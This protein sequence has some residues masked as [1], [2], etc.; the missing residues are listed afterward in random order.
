MKNKKQ[1][2]KIRIYGDK[3]LKKVADSVEEITPDLKKFI[4]N[5]TYTMYLTDGIGL[6]APQVGI[7]LRIFVVDPYWYKEEKKKNPRIFI[8]PEFIEFEGESTAEEGCLS[9][10]N[11]YEKVNRAQKVVISALDEYGKRFTLEAEDMFARVLQ[12]EFDHLEGVLFVE[13]IPKL[14]QVFIKKKLKELERSTDEN[15][16]NILKNED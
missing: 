10:P 4:E 15:G 5:L 3:T 13:K 12:H 7:S 16:V 9:L 1:L 8:N 14:R 11:I 2:L 6:A